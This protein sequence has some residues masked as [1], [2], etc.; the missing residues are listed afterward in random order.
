MNKSTI[1]NIQANQQAIS[2]AIEGVSSMQSIQDEVREEYEGKTEKGQET[3]DNMYPWLQDF[4]DL[5]LSDL[6]EALE[7]ASGLDLES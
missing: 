1:M 5:D 6:Q 2:G 4:L 3:M 7:V